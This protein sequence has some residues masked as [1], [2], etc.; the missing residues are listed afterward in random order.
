MN[1]LA[2]A[3]RAE[4]AGVEPARRCCKAAERTG[5]GGAALG[6]ARSAAVARLAVRLEADPAAGLEFE[7]R[8]AQAHCRISYLR[9]LFLGHGSL[10]LGAAGSHLEFVVPLEMSDELAAQLAALGM[11]ARSRERRGRAVLTWKSAETI[12]DFLR[13]AGGTAATLELET[14]LETRALR[15]H[16]NRALNAE[17]ANVERSVA[18][19]RRQL[20][21]IDAL[22]AGGRL[23]RLPRGL[24]AV[25]G[26]RRRSP[27]AT[28]GQL[29][30]ELGTSRAH[31]QRAFE[32][33]EQH[34]LQLQ[35]GPA[36]PS[37]ASR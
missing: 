12:I 36:G 19:A 2:S 21:A 4:L 3:I 25:A 24:R 6:R 11:P 20:A 13:R 33:I 37:S 27:E 22:D 35:A 17:S 10:S 23:Q 28:F 18:T 8:R 29:A 26:A 7:W 30:R 14:Q 34:A 15:A 16:L 32:Q 9:G 31:V 1:E 5:L